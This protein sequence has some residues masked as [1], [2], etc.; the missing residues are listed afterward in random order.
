[1]EKANFTLLF[2]QLLNQIYIVIRNNSLCTDLNHPMKV[3]NFLH[4]KKQ[5]IVLGFLFCFDGFSHRFQVSLKL[6]PEKLCG[7]SL[8]DFTINPL[9]A[10]DGYEL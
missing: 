7:M 4:S 6:K 9:H 8:S 2:G 10:V 1:M 5:G 3:E